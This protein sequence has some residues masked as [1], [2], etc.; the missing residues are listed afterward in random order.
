[1]VGEQTN[2]R[3]SKL[4]S[5]SEAEKV[6]LICGQQYKINQIQ[7][8]VERLTCA[9]EA[10]QC[11]LCADKDKTIEEQNDVIKAL[12]AKIYG[13]S[14]ERRSKGKGGRDDNK[15]GKKGNSGP[16]VRLPS[17]QYPNARIKD[18]TVSDTTPPKC[19]DC[20]KEMTD[21]GLRETSERLELIPMELFIVRQHRVRYHCKCCQNAPQT[22]A[23]PARIAPN[24]SLNDSVLIEASIAKFYDL[25]PTQRYAKMLS[26][27]SIDIS[28]KLLL[29]AQHTLAL[30]YYSVYLK[31]KKE[32]QSSRVINADESPHRMLERN[33]GNY[34]W[35]LWAFC[36]R[37]SV[38]FE[39]HNTRAGTVSIKFLLEAELVL[40]LVS[41]VYSGYTRTIREVNEYRQDKGLPLMVSAHC[42]DHSRRYFFKVQEHELAEKVL[43]VYETIYKLEEGVQQMLKEPKYLE[44]EN[45]KKAL[46]L[47]QTMDPHFQKIYNLSCEI[48]LENT[49][50]SSIGTAANYFLKNLRGLTVFMTD[51]EIPISN[52]FA[53]RSIR[54]PVI[55]RKTWLGTHSQKGAVTTAIHFS[56]LESCKLNGL[57]PREYYNYLGQLYRDGKELITPSEY[58]QIMAKPPPAP[59]GTTK[60]KK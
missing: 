49:P 59:P 53:E 41:D 30:A 13:R 46:Q 33:E 57:N 51:L 48:L 45:S 15:G 19:L 25:I 58:R 52:S 32:V 37:Y 44:P 18:E 11:I 31:I 55:G 40:V 38:Y 27:S 35:Y 16:R 54:N 6:A 60:I 36:T 29:A 34:S 12:K 28:D 26:R 23:L 50:T 5:L 42:N 9:H 3:V 20:T 14:S 17:E 1:M 24:T 56:L 10:G 21:S 39:I 2:D 8:R 47:R 4:R 43:D 22:A 7:D